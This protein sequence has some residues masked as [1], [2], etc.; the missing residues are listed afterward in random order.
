MGSEVYGSDFPV[1]GVVEM[2]GEQ[3]RIRENHGSTGVVE[4]LDGVMA[5][6]K[7]YWTFQ[8]DRAVLIDPKPTQEQPGG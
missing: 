1:G 2:Y 4:Y 5:S 3:Y 6:N 7:F 8:G